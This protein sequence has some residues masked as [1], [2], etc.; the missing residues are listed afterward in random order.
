LVANNVSD[1]AKYMQRNFT[2]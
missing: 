2:N 1:N